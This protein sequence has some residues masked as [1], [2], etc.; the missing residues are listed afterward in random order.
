MV[1]ILGEPYTV[2]LHS[3]LVGEDGHVFLSGNSIEGAMFYALLIINHI[4]DNNKI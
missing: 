4:H 2:G 1:G 3:I